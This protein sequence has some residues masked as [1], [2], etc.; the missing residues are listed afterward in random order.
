[1]HAT[2]VMAAKE[3]QLTQDAQNGKSRRQYKNWS[4][5]EHYTLAVC[6][7]FYGMAMDKMC[8]ALSSRTETQ[9]IVLVVVQNETSY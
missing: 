1:M 5:F 6:W 3:R 9:V 8:L 7:R 4:D 2:Q